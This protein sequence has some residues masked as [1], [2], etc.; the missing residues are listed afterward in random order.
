MARAAS[1]GAPGD[2]RAGM[3]FL[4]GARRAP[5]TALMNRRLACGIGA[6][7][8]LHLALLMLQFGIPGLG[9]P[10]SRA[11]VQVRL[12]ASV[13]LRAPPAPPEP[14]L[15]SPT[16]AAAPA[17]APVQGL[18]L[19]AP[20][21]RAPQA[22]AKGP[23]RQARRV[24]TPLPAR[25][26]PAPATRVIAQDGGGRDDFVVPLARP[27]EAQLRSLDPK[28]AQQGSD[29]GTAASSAQAEAEAVALAEQRHREERLAQQALQRREDELQRLN[30]EAAA[31]QAHQQRQAA[32]EFAQRAEQQET[33]RA[34]LARREQQQSAE[35]LAALE[36]RKQDEA[37]QRKR[38]AA[39]ELGRQ[40][41]QQ[42]AQQQD[43][44]QARLKLEQQLRL[45][46]AQAQQKA[47][48]LARQQAEEQ[49]RLKAEQL[50]RQQAEAAQRQQAEQLAQRQAEQQARQLAEQQA[51]QRAEAERARSAERGAGGSEAGAGAAAGGAGAPARPGGST[52]AERARA[53]LKGLDILS[54]M[55]PPRRRE[56]SDGGRR[57]VVVGVAER[58]VPLRMYVESFRQKVERNGGLNYTSA[59]KDR[60]RID[61]LVSVALRSDGSVEDVTIVRSSGRSDTDD[62]VRRIVRLNA[63]YSPFPPN[64]AGR[65]DVI[66]I[67]R[68]WRFDETLTLLEELH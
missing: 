33:L 51:G 48:L 4:A 36:A 12:A 62:A 39:E 17:R 67:R 64:I 61:P 60:V 2:A 31:A 28:E 25:D 6:S 43:E 15:E 1:G 66:E 30:Q 22:P 57:R 27:E 9:L 3:S 42:L 26:T 14:A 50:A 47:E 24:S 18:T 8:M 56:A 29:T 52:L 44:L 20:A 7:L 35:R 55:P 11:P 54:G 10:G 5:S 53:A 45:Q 34:E 19:L 46:Q 37:A 41:A 16:P 63:R 13:A 59:L 49:A 23:P 32:E 58:D 40:K 38:E 65:Y 21:P 68:V